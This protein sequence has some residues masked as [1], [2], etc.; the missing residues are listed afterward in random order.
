MSNQVQKFKQTKAEPAVNSG[1]KGSF[2]DYARMQALFPA[3]PL[4]NDYKDEAIET[5]GFQKLFTE[6]HLIAID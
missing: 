6:D 2:A 4:Y 3:S 5:L 1:T